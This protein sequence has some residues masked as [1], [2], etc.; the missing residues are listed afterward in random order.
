VN[1]PR[2]PPD[3]FPLWGVLALPGG[4][5]FGALIGI[6]VGALFG[7]PGIGA[8]IGA[9]LGVGIGLSLLAA[10]IVLVSADY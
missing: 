5:I 3:T 6:F 2:R 10:A 8:A 9:G 4:A 7:I 1:A